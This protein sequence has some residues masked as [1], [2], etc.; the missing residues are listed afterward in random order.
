VIFV[1]PSVRGA[2]RRV[3]NRI[4]LAIAKIHSLHFLQIEWSRAAAS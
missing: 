2:G 1:A 4:E 3:C